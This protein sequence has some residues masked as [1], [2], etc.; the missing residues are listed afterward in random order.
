[1]L[2]FYLGFALLLVIYGVIVYNGLIRKKN[3]VEE[4]WSGIDVQLKKRYNIIPNLVEIVKGY[5]KHENDVLKNVIAAR[6]SAVSATTV[7]GQQEAE[8]HLNQSF[9][10]LFALAEQYPDLKANTNFLQ[11]QSELSDIENDIEKARRYYNGTVREKNT[12]M[13]TFPSSIFAQLYGFEKSNYFELDS[14][15]EAEMPEIKF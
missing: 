12:A 9:G 4:G 2:Y 15:H 7:A 5:T 3:M 11:L 1:M 10:K 13:E 14:Y 8:T 6:N